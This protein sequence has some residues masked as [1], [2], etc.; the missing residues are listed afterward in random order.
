MVITKILSKTHLQENIASMLDETDGPENI[1]N[2]T[3][4]IC[5]SGLIMLITKLL[6]AKDQILDNRVPLDRLNVCIT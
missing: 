3:L 1:D 2:F 5:L 4:N 6:D